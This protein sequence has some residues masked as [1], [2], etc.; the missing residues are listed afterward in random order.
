MNG[1][2]HIL[3]AAD[4]NDFAIDGKRMPLGVVAF[5]VALAVEFF[6]VEILH[7]DVECR[8]SPR[9]MIVV[10]GNDK[11]ETGKRDTRRVKTG[12]TKI[13]HVPRVR[14]AEGEV[15][16]VREERLARCGVRAGDDPVVRARSAAV[17]I[18]QAE[19]C[20]EGVSVVWNRLRG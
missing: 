10:A 11:R 1:E 19:K 4:V 5:V 20:E 2:D 14:L 9:D 13:C 12:G 17:A 7:I 16:I 8:E 6:D 15:H 18:R 3:A